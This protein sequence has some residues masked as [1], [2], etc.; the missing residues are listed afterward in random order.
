MVLRLLLLLALIGA[1]SP[2]ALGQAFE[3]GYVVRSSGDTLRGAVE[4]DFWEEPP[5]LIR[6]RRTAEGEVESFLP[7]QLRAVS[8]TGGRYFRFLR[9]PIDHAAKNVVSQLPRENRSAIQTDSLLAEVLVDG[10]ASLVRVVMPDIIHF[11]VL[12]PSRPP[13]DLSER[14]YLRQDT[15]GKWILVNGNN[16]RSQLGVYFG[17]CASVTSV[18]QKAPFSAQGLSAVVMAYNEACGS[19]QKPSRNLLAEAQPRRKL[20]L[21]GGVLAGAR[22]NRIESNASDLAGPCTDCLVQPFGGFY[23]EVL[24]PSRKAAVYGELTLSRFNNTNVLYYPRTYTQSV[25]KYTALLG[26]ARLGV[27]LFFPLAHDN[28]L[29]FGLGYEVNK[30]IN[31]AIT[32]ISGTPVDAGAAETGFASTVVMPNV[33]LGWGSGRFSA[34]LDGQMYRDYD[35]ELDD[36]GPVFFDSN[37]ALRVSLGYQLGRNSDEKVSPR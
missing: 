19:P 9:L 27:R 13:L 6:F 4:N 28:K 29:L 22:Y 31:P 18:A 25:Y 24:Q 2:I 16:Y 15:D 34:C 10:T 5:T 23:A 26:T 7:H 21:Q 14:K 32:T 36:Y 3:P 11:V 30:T 8:F 20:A 17:E 35:G 33:T 37:F 12:L 1:Y